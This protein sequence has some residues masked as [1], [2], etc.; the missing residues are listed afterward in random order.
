MRLPIMMLCVLI[1]VS[2][3][4]DGFIFLFIRRLHGSD[5]KWPRIYALSSVVCWLVLAVA[6]LIPRRDAEQSI[7]PIM[8]IL[9]GY[10]TIYFS[11]IVF[12]LIALIGLI[13]KLWKG[14]ALHTGTLVGVPCAVCVFLIM[15]WGAIWGRRQ[16]ETTYVEIASERLPASFNGFKIVQLSDLHVGTW[17]N[18]TTFV[19]E[20]VDRVNALN[21][22]VILFTGDIVNRQSTELEPFV[23]VLS[24][25]K[26]P[27]GVYSVLGN[28]DYGLYMNWDS[29]ESRL[30]DIGKLAELQKRMGWTLLNNEHSFLVNGTDSIALIGVENWGEPPFGEMGD[31]DKAYP[32][33][34]Q[35][36]YHQTDSLFKILMSHNPEHW[37]LKVKE[38]SNID[39]TLSG[40]TH[41]MQFMLKAG[42]WKW[43]PSQYKYEQWA[44]LY[45]DRGKTG[46]PVNCYVNVGSGEVGM[47]FRIGATPEITVITLSQ[48]PDK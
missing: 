33:S 37:R 24:R 10:L 31:L 36:R 20:L 46:T 13:P 4:V 47:P 23:Q 16:L 43:S 17:G 28:H 48:K 41:A 44:G 1:A 21:P 2:L 5:R 8:W 39:L 30:A 12:I 18:D 38:N 32:P 42:K 22:D 15:W 7:L 14:R 26:A 27:R 3:I 45:T 11:K 19:S 6:L 29:E 34:G 25:L 35:G 40:H 9:Y